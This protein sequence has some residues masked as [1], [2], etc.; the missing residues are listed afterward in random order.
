M[1]ANPRNHLRLTT[2]QLVI[3]WGINVI[4]VAQVWFTAT[5]PWVKL[6]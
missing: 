6:P 4:A 1:E 3:L 5:P 2:R